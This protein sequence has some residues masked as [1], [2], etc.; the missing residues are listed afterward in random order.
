MID[1][2]FLTLIGLAVYYA[3]WAAFIDYTQRYTPETSRLVRVLDASWQPVATGL[4]FTARWS[5][6][7]RLISVR[8]GRR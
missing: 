7:N 6:L 4:R 3:L 5:G 1:Q 2:I 8:A